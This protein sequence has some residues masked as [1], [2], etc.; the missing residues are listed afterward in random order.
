MKPLPELG[1]F[2]GC[3]IPAA[4]EADQGAPTPPQ[5]HLLKGSSLLAACPFPVPTV[6]LP[7]ADHVVRVGISH[8][9][10]GKLRV[11]SSDAV[12]GVGVMRLL[13]R[14]QCHKGK[15]PEFGVTG[16]VVAGGVVTPSKL[17]SVLGE[18]GTN[19]S[20]NLTPVSLTHWQR[21]PRSFR[22]SCCAQSCWGG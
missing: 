9:S 18:Q 4:A 11:P 21:P 7:H 10:H 6:S 8:P 15:C 20:S 1:S 19:L 5:S 17:H 3:H 13:S 22:P 2:T 14:D 16:F 12:T